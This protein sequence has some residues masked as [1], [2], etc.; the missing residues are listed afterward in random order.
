M[1]KVDFNQKDK[2]PDSDVYFALIKLAFLSNK[3][4][5]A[6]SVPLKMYA[7]SFPLK[8]PWFDKITLS[9]NNILYIGPIGFPS[10]PS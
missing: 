2:F 6:N 5:I 1:S 7:T 9:P 3:P 8:D 4:C 10:K